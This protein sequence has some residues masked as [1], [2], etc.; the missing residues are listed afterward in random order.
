MTIAVI[1]VGAVVAL[2]MPRA[3]MVSDLKK[4]PKKGSF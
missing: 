2:A 1:A 3:A 4:M